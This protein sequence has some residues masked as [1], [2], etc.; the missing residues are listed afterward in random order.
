MI[1]PPVFIA[2]VLDKEPSLT[3]IW[4]SH[5]SLACLG[6][7]LCRKDW[8]WLFA[9]VPL[10][11]YAV[12]FGAIDLWDRSVGPAILEVSS[13]FFVEWHIAMALVVAAPLVG[14]CSGLRR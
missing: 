1:H 9:V 11:S 7:Y 14:F 8:R 12:W 4:L 3:A 5:L 6:Y 2:E 13:S 10:S